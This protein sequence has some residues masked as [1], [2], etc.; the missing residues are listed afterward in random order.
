MSLG[1]SWQLFHAENADLRLLTREEHKAR[2][3]AGA[4]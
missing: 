1:E 3:A 2:H 4:K